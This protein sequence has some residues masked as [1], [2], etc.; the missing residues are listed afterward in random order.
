M[1]CKEFV[2]I[3]KAKNLLISQVYFPAELPN[4][5][6]NIGNQIQL[7]RNQQELNRERCNINLDT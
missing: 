3:C 4:T 7:L 1:V 5:E 2:K 6:N